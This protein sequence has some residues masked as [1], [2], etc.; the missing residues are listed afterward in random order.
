MPGRPENRRPVQIAVRLLEG[1]S[2]VVNRHNGSA[3]IPTANTPNGE[4]G[5]GYRPELDVVRFLAF[6]VVFLHHIL[7]LPKPVPGQYGW[8]VPLALVESCA[9]G[10]CLFFALSAYLITG[11]LLRERESTGTISVR[12][13]YVRRVLRIWPLYFFG[14]AIGVALAIVIHVPSD[15]TGFAWFMLFA[16]N[17]YCGAFGWLHNPMNQLWSI[18]VEE[19]FYL[20]WPW[21][22][23]RLSKR[24]LMACALFFIV[25]ANAA[26]LILQKDRANADRM[27]WTNTFVQFEMFAAGI[28]LALSGK[29]AAWRNAGIGLGLTCAG[30]VLWFL[31]SLQLEAKE[32]AGGA[33]AIGGL[34]LMTAYGLIALGCAAI[35]QGFNMMGPSY[36]PQWAVY[37]GRRSY[38]LYVYHQLAIGF[39]NACFQSRRGVV[40]LAVSIPLALL[41]TVAAAVV[42]YDLI[43]SPFLRLKRRFEIEHSRPI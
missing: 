14:V 17:V 40:A 13:F 11:L 7:P 3:A 21:P 1:W 30:P 43:E 15:V 12:K 6:L 4:A 19:Q 23:R 42:S 20:L 5:G 22:I 16:G 28:L 34:A 32:P 39:A 24:G 41:L 26:M 27:I 37:L 18:S 35:L 10:L 25:A 38:G 29:R 8:R 9:D 31:A 36:M 2:I 33:G